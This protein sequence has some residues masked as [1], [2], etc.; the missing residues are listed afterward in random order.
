MF[1]E[2]DITKQDVLLAIY[3]G[4]KDAF[5]EANDDLVE[6]PP[7]GGFGIVGAVKVAVLASMP[8]PKEILDAI[9]GATE[10]R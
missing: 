3:E 1:A 4:V 10:T 9:R 6:C 8:E 5:K 2:L 7:F